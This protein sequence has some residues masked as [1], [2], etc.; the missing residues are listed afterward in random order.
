MEIR[1]GIKPITV[2]VLSG[3]PDKQERPVEKQNIRPSAFI[4]LFLQTVT[5]I[6]Q[7]GLGAAFMRPT[8]DRGQERQFVIKLFDHDPLVARAVKQRDDMTLRFLGSLMFC[9][10][11]QTSRRRDNADFKAIKRDLT[12]LLG[13]PWDFYASVSFYTALLG[14]HEITDVPGLWANPGR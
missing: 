4:E 5:E 11:L 7:D 3:L 12:V 10:L 6:E 9:E 1:S 2:P 14:R 8:R 13:G